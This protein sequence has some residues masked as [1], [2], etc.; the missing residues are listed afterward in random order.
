MN[1][2]LRVPPVITGHVVPATPDDVVR[3]DSSGRE[4]PKD[5]F[6]RP[7]SRLNRVYHYV[8]APGLVALVS[9]NDVIVVPGL[10][11]AGVVLEE[12]E[13]ARSVT[14]SSAVNHGAPHVALGV[15]GTA[16]VAEVVSRVERLA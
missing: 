5:R 12:D 7:R 2:L 13:P 6:E 3:N 9:W 16:G 8:V 10:G 14:C 15:R 1:S 11:R 4:L